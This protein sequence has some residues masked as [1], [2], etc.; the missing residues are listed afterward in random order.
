MEWWIK[1]I[2]RTIR[3]LLSTKGCKKTLP[4]TRTYHSKQLEVEKTLAILASFSANGCPDAWQNQKSETSVEGSSFPPSHP[5]SKNIQLWGTSISTS[6][7][8]IWVG[9]FIPY[10]QK[11]HL[12]MLD[13]LAPSFFLAMICR[14]SV[15]L[16]DYQWVCFLAQSM[17]Q[18]MFSCPNTLSP[19]T[20]RTAILVNVWWCF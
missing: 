16:E 8:T 18:P 9:N 12:H 11:V 5:G 10:K 14:K 2:Q 20:A 17:G 3:S 13:F 15:S 6:W 1:R 19:G 7:T 4:P